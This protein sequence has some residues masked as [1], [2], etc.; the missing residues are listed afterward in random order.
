MRAPQGTSI[1]AIR[2]I[3]ISNIVCSTTKS[4]ASQWREF[5]P[6]VSASLQSTAVACSVITGVPGHAIEDIQIDN[7]VV[8]H[9][10]GGPEQD[11]KIAVPEKE[12][13]YPEPTMFGTTPAHG[14]FIRH[15]KGID[16]T[17]LKLQ[18]AAVDR[19][20][21]FLLNDVEDAQFALLRLPQA[22]NVAAFSLDDVRNFSLLQSRPLADTWIEKADKREIQPARA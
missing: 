22:A 2:R 7:I 3:S 16:L 14:F 10:G 17:Q 20:P 1:G 9:P 19:R 15:V 12:A 8:R 6:T 21:A 5:A 13:V 18:T 11:A 4:H